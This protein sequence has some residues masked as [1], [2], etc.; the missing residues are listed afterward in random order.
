MDYLDRPDSIQITTASV[1]EVRR[2]DSACRLPFLADAGGGEN[3][4]CGVFDPHS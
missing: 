3:H 2:D 1:I 4:V